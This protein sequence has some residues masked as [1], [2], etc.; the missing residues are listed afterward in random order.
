MSITKNKVVHVKKLTKQDCEWYTF[1]EGDNVPEDLLSLFLEQGGT[2]KEEDKKEL[3]AEEL[4]EKV[5]EYKE[6]L[7][8]DGK[9]NYSNND[10][11]KS[12]GRKKKW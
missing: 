10:K 5:K 8:D 4:S 9:R 1:Y 3:L 7:K 6:D 2:L 11:K 12:P